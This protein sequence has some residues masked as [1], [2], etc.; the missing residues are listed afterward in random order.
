LSLDE[1]RVFVTGLA[2]K[3]IAS[4]DERRPFA[5]KG[6]AAVVNIEGRPV[7]YATFEPG[8]R[9]SEHVK[10]IAGTDSCQTNHLGYVLSGQMHVV[11]D[12]GSETEFGPGDVFAIH[13]GH[14]AWTVGDD[15]CVTVD[16]GQV[17]EYAKA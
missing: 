15:A 17:G 1:R 14:D 4:P 7:L 8:W 5:A 9:W 16:F 10:P 13:P 3:N 12:D 11:M 6:G 2:K